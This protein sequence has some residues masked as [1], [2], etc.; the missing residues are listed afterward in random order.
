MRLFRYILLMAIVLLTAACSSESTVQEEKVVQVD[1]QY[2]M[3]FGTS[4]AT[5]SAN[6]MRAATASTLKDGFKVDVWKGFGGSAQQ[7]VMNG[8][9][10]NYSVVD[11]KDKWEYIGV[12][13]QIERYWDMGAFPYDFRAVSPYM[14]ESQA[15]PDGITISKSFQAQTLTNEVLNVDAA[16]CEP[17]VV[18]HVTR[19]KT[20]SNY[21]D[22][23][24]IKDAAI[25]ETS[26][27]NGTRGVHMPFHHLVSKIGFRIFIDNAQPDRPEWQNDYMIQIKNIVI[28]VQRSE[29]FITKSNK[30]TA[31][32]AQG[33]GH[34]TFSDNTTTTDEF[35]VLSHNAYEGSSQNLHY[36]LNRETALD[37]SPDCLHQIPQTGVKVHVKLTLKT[38]HVSEDQ[39][40][41][42]YDS[43]LKLDNQDTF[44]WDPETKYIYYLHIPNLHSHEIYLNSCEIEPWDEVRTTEIPVEL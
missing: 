6:V 20:G 18:S 25:N 34:G 17:C 2:P 10:V 14:A 23:D 38:N 41:F 5:E 15:T 31:T 16:A 26:K 40:E 22:T 11:A 1:Q 33:L 29:G 9:Q 36:H 30:Y 27:S 43:W 24:V 7:S 28:T 19:Q 42:Q 12:N 3:V 21:D 8:Y 39:T 32:N 37:L 35:T 13:G 4:Y 44:T